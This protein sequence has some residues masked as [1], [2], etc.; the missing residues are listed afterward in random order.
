MRSACTSVV[1]APPQKAEIPV[2][3][4]GHLQAR[5][6]CRNGKQMVIQKDNHA[7][8]LVIQHHLQK[9]TQVIHD[10]YMINT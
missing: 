7:S 8:D 3:D 4:R 9:Q 6:P 1:R 5:M 2:V 10:E